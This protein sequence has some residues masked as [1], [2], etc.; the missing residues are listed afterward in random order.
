[1]YLRSLKKHSNEGG[2]EVS[3][4]LLSRWAA[5]QED[6]ERIGKKVKSL[7]EKNGAEFEIGQIFSGQNTGQFLAVIRFTDWERF[8]RTLYAISKDPEYQEAL[9]EA[10][11]LGQLQER[12]IVVSRDL[13]A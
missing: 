4:I 3:I 13:S 11:S 5:K 12:S 2:T 9:T 6:V 10:H 1:M 8:G 7:L